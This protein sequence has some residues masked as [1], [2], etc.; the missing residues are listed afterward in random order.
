MPYGPRGIDGGSN[1]GNSQLAFGDEQYFEFVYNDV[2][3]GLSIGKPVYVD[4]T[5]AAEFNSKL[6][7]TALVPAAGRT[8]GRVVL[9]T[10][11]KVLPNIF[12]VGVFAPDDQNPGLLPAPGDTIRVCVFG[13]TIVS[14]QSPVSSIAVL[15]GSTLIA[16]SAVSDAVP[17]GR[18]SGIN[19]GIALATRS[20]IAN[21]GQIVAAG[22]ATSTLINA[23][24]NLT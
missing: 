5:D 9:G 3:G 19:I 23:F 4:V 24:V 12:P 16:S 7:S 14:V 15:V 21:G 18:S 17:G 11:A 1:T 13:R 6:A 10:N 20:V 2:A 8:G 22:S